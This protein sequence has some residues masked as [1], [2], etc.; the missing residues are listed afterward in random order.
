MIERLFQ[1]VFQVGKVLMGTLALRGV[2][3][4]RAALACVIDAKD[5]SDQSLMF[6]LAISH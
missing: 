2:D 5:P 1:P 6:A 3:M 4:N